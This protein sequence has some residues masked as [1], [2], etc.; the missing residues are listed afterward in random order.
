MKSLFYIVHLIIA[1]SASTSWAH[2]SRS[3]Q[4][5]EPNFELEAI[6]ENGE[7][8][9][10]ILSPDEESRMLLFGLDYISTNIVSGSMV[11]LLMPE[12]R[13]QIMS[14]ML[15]SAESSSSTE[16]FSTGISYKITACINQPPPVS[17]GD[18]T[19]CHGRTCV[20]YP[21]S[22]NTCEFFKVLCKA[23]GGDLGHNICWF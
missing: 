5:T 9:V 19:H 20:C 22:E 21:D 8:R 15:P 12:T 13:R 3:T 16:S 10:S 1:V 17:K 7:S 11:Q 18:G 23:L 14:M 4:E 2:D 6:C